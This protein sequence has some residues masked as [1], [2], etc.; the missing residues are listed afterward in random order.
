M[1]FLLPPLPPTF[2][3]ALRDVRAHAMDARRAAAERL[4]K[5]DDT[6][7]AQALAGLFALAG[8]KD[9]RVRA[10]SLVSLRQLP[11]PS[12]LPLLLERVE[13]PHPDVRELAVVALGALRGPE[14]ERTLHTLTAHERAEVRF[15]ALQSYVE[16]SA[17]PDASALLARLT[18][19]DSAVRAMAARCSR[20]LGVRAQDALIGAL[21]DADV[22]TR[23]EAALAL[24]ALGDGSGQRGLYEALD[25]PDLQLEALDAIGTLRV[26]ALRDAVAA[27]ASSL[28]G[29]RWLKAAAARALVLLGDDL[30]VAA[31]RE[32]LRGL[33]R[34]GRSYAAEV[35]GELGLVALVPDLVRLAQRPRG[36]DPVAVASA[37]GALLPRDAR[38]RQG[39]ERLAR[40]ADEAGATAR[41]ALGR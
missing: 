15:A 23:A 33:R 37:L 28:L 20:V 24:C 21:E 26:H 32:V 1:T 12:A 25:L 8:D 4:G 6:Q 22:E 36:A 17:E 2:E 18:D 10:E 3:A 27:L 9:A 5:A 19:P 34:D 38:A 31:L 30:G 39:L 13:D 14:V 41:A 7:R 35:A 16:I 29:P 11:E 40:R